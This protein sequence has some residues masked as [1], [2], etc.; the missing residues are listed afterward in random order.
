MCNDEWRVG[1]LFLKEVGTDTL[2]ASDI[3]DDW[4][5]SEECDDGDVQE[6]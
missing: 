4:C 6:G 3:A 5:D 1:Y 2:A